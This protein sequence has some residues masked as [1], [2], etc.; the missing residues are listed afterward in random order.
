[1]EYG[2]NRLPDWSWKRLVC[3]NT[4]RRRYYFVMPICREFVMLI[5][6]ISVFG[7]VIPAFFILT[8]KTYLER[9]YHTALSPEIILSVNESGYNNDEFIFY[10]IKYFEKYTRN[11]TAKVNRL[12]LLNRYGVHY[13]YLFLKFCKVYNIIPFGFPP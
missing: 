3:G 11:R 8:G 9:W 13:T 7:E 6:V 4:R 12:F 2:R 10:W 5:K 1:M